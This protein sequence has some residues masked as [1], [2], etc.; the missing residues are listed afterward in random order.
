M[1]ARPINRLAQNGLAKDE[2]ALLSYECPEVVPQRKA[3]PM[4]YRFLPIASL[5]IALCVSAQALAQKDMTG[6][7]HEGTVVSVTG[8]KLVMTGKDGKEHTHTLLLDAKVSCDGNA[9][10]LEDLKPG[11]RIR[12]TTKEG[13]MQTAT[14]IEALDKREEFEKRD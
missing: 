4:M 2:G 8:D 13:D 7:T 12:V 5:A 6:K 11:M 9:C 14:R 1:R 3:N 10:K